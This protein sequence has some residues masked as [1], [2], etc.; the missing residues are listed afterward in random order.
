MELHGHRGLA[1]D[2][3]RARRSSW[4]GRRCPCSGCRWPPEA[5]EPRGR[6]ADAGGGGVAA[7]APC[8]QGPPGARA[9]APHAYIFDAHLLM[10]DDPLLLDRAIAVIRQD[11]VNGEWALRT[12]AEQLHAHVRR[13]HRPLPARAQRRP[14]RRARPRAD[15]PGRRAGRAHALAPARA[16]HRRG[17]PPHAV[18]PRGAGLGA[19]AGRGHRLGLGHAPHRR[20]WPA[21]S[22]CPRS[23]AC[24]TRRAAHRA[25]RA[26]GRGRHARRGCSWSRP[27]RCSRASARC[28]TGTA[29]E[30]AR[31][32]DMRGAARGDARRRDHPPARQRR[33][34][35]RGGDR[36][37]ARGGG[38]RALPLR[39]P[40]RPLAPVAERRAAVR[41]LPPAPGA[42]E[43]A[44]VT[45]RTWDVG[46]E[47][48]P[49][50]APPAPTR[51]WASA[52]LRLLRRA[53]EAVPHADPRAAARLRARA[54]PDHV[55]LHLR[56]A[57][58]CGRPWT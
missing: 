50:A 51:R 24:A 55:P 30:E 29:R 4:S 43:P 37:P 26:G 3:G 39:V 6:A 15:Q 52:A 44:A 42:H 57:P 8:H 45:V 35:R 18:G 54:A 17:E 31:L 34:P 56:A 9:G 27:R 21:R 7:A 28:R 2:R 49:P 23:W 16:V 22:A 53:P 38:H 14:R 25:G 10:L 20:S 41:G 46:P 5:V 13:V 58:T 32:Q 47:D 1:G 40:A 48:L 19:R 33:V 12:V 36:A 11:R